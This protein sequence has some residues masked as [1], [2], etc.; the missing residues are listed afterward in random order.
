MTMKQR[1]ELVDI[2]GLTRG[3]LL[4]PGAFLAVTSLNNRLPYHNDSLNA[5]VTAS[6]RLSEQ[7]LDAWR[8]FMRDH[9]DEGAEG[10]G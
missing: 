7:E 6:F 10:E 4:E 8:A 1:L 2:D 3:D 5:R 9:D